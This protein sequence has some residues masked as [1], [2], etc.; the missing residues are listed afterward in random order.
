MLVLNYLPEFSKKILKELHVLVANFPE[1]PDVFSLDKF[2][3]FDLTNHVGVLVL[4]ILKY[5]QT[6]TVFPQICV[7]RCE[8][9]DFKES[10]GADE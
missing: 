2:P 1:R 7:R 6:G 9:I 10:C 3:V 5:L 8:I 4:A